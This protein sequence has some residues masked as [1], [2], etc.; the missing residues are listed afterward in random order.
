MKIYNISDDFETNING[1]ADDL[2]IKLDKSYVSRNCMRVRLIK[3][4]ENKNYQRVGFS[5]N[6]DGSRKKVNS[7]CWHGY[8]DFLIEMYKYHPNARVV[9]AQATYLNKEDF[10]QKYPDT[11][12]NNIGSMVDPL[13]YSDACLCH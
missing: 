9:T 3:I 11:A 13:Y 5:K 7:I 8:K 10:E 12:F 4:K 2:N 6:K 1:I